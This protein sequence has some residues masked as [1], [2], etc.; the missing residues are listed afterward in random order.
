MKT[1]RWSAL[2]ALA[3]FMPAD[4]SVHAAG[5]GQPPQRTAIDEFVVYAIDA[6]EYELVR[7]NF[8]TANDDGVSPARLVKISPLDA[9]VQVHCLGD[10]TLQIFNPSNPGSVNWPCSLQE[11]DREGLAFTTRLKDLYDG[12]VI[13]VFD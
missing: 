1:R 10:N 12:I 2:P 13:A 9:T 8:G 11:I 7:H 6:D 3:A 4:T 5:Q